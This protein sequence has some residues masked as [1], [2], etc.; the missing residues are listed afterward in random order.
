MRKWIVGDV[1]IWPEADWFAKGR[2]K[3]EFFKKGTRLVAAQI[4]EIG[5]V[6]VKL[7]VLRCDVV[8]DV[9]ARGVKVLRQGEV[10]TRKLATLKKCKAV[11]TDWGGKEGESAR[12][13]VVSKFTR[14]VS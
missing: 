11:R 5:S 9:S 2:K 6:Y 13:I 3:K 8:Y 14:P 12:A 7:T 10:I 4:L 1:L